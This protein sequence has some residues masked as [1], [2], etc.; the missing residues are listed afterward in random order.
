MG[1][2]FNIVLYAPD[3]KAANDAAK[4]AFGRIAELNRIMSDY[5]EDSELMKLCRRAGSGPVPVSEDLFKVLQ[6][7]QEISRLS[8]GAFD[9]SISPVVRLW[10]KA[11]RT[12]SSA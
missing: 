2:L 8:D 6:A 9:V 7:A 12:G 1:T 3:E 11:R 5:Q 10:R 4:D